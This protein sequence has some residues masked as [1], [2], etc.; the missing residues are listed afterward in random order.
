MNQTNIFEDHNLNSS[1]ISF[2]CFLDENFK[3]EYYIS[4]GEDQKGIN[5]YK[6]WMKLKIF[7]YQ[8]KTY[9]I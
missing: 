2:G 1:N 7:K 8:A 5:F 4:I 6:I 3:D 9:L